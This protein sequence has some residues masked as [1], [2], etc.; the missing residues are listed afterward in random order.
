MIRFRIGFAVFVVALGAGLVFFAVRTS[1]EPAPAEAPAIS[2]EPPQ[3][4]LSSTFRRGTH[5]ITGAFSVPTACHAIEASVTVDTEAD[6]DIIRISISA[7]PDGGPCLMLPAEKT[8]LLSASAEENAVIEA[9]VNGVPAEI[10]HE[11]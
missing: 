11:S 2:P 1:E 4:I 8:F 10:L 5:S 7:P 6:P 3:V 9:S